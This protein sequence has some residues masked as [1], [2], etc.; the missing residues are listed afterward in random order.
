MS[1]PVCELFPQLK[2]DLDLIEV[3]NGKSL[4]ISEKE[5]I[6]TALQEN[7]FVKHLQECSYDMTVL[8][9]QM[10]KFSSR[11]LIP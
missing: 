3:L 2:L 10:R 9:N 4:K 11:E 8:Q 7:D 5:F 1:N 6:C